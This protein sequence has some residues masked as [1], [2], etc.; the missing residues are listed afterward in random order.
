MYANELTESIM[1]VFSEGF[2]YVTG[3]ILKVE[4]NKKM[5]S[6]MTIDSG[7]SCCR[8][9]AKRFSTCVISTCLRQVRL[10]VMELETGFRN[11]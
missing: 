6:K 10:I 11:L 5:G 1:K 4:A 3:T 7:V 2:R 8:S 9:G